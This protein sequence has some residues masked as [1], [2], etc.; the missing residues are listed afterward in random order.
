[1]RVEPENRDVPVARREALDDADVGAAA[2]A[3]HERARGQVGGDG[4]RLHRERLLLDHRH[5]RIVERERGRLD[6][7]LAP[8]APRA[9]HA[10]E[11]G[12]EGAAAAVALVALVDRDGGERPAVGTASAQQAHSFAFS[13]ATPHASTCMPTRS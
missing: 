10:D 6:H 12:G 2:A 4:K 7:R 3:E 8:V 13:K 11:P 1:M 9:R 5:L